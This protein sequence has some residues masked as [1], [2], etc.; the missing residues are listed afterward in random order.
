MLSGTPTYWKT[1]FPA[2]RLGAPKKT[3]FLRETPSTPFARRRCG[4]GFG[5]ANLQ[6]TRALRQQES[7]VSE[8]RST[9]S[10]GESVGVPTFQQAIQRLQN[11]W[12]E[13]TK[14]VVWLP[15]STE[16]G[17]GTMNPATFLR[18]LGPEPWHVCY[19]EPSIR[20]DDSRFGD[21][22]NRVQRHTQFQVILKPEPGNAQEL[23]LGS[24]EV[25][26]INVKKHDVRFVEDNW[27]SP[28]LG[29]WGLGWE[30]WLDGMEIT[31]FTYFQQAGGMQTDPVSV[32]I[33]YGLERILMSLQGVNH[34]KD[35]RYNDDVTYG[36]LFLQNEYEMSCYNIN[37]ASVEDARKR[38]QLFYKEGME[39]VE[40]K[41][42]VPAYDNLLKASHAF[43]VLD[44]RGAVGVTERAKL[45]GQ[46]RNLS[47]DCAEL[48]VER[49]EEL[50]FP[51]GQSRLG[52]LGDA[53]AEACGS[54]PL[55]SAQDFLLELGSEELPADEV[56]SAAGQ[57]SSRLRELLA[58]LRLEHGEVV[59]SGTPRRIFAV[60]RGLSPKQEDRVEEV[61][62][63]PAKIAFDGEGNPTKAVLGYCKKNG[64][65]VEDIEL[66]ADK[67][68]VEYCWVTKSVR[69][70][71]TGDLLSARLPDLVSKLQFRKSM[72]WSS[73]ATY[74]RPLR[75]I[76]ALHGD[77]VVPFV[78]CGVQSGRTSLGLRDGF[79]VPE[80]EIPTASGYFGQ[81]E[82][83]SLMVDMEKRRGAI[84][85]QSQALAAAAGGAIPEG[86]RQELLPEVTNLVEYPTAIMGSF[87]QDFLKL[88]KEILVMVMKK[89]QRYFP[90]E[91]AKTGQLLPSFVTIANGE[92][93][94]AT[95]RGGNEAVLTA[96]F[97]DADF[98]YKLDMQKRL[99]D[100][101]PL[102]Q[103]TMFQK[104]L[105]TMLDKADR[106][107]ALVG[108]LA[109]AMGLAGA[110]EVALQASHLS[111]ADLATSVVTEFTALAGVMGKHYALKDGAPVEVAEAIFESVLPRN[112]SD[113]VPKTPAGILVAVADRL[114]SLVGLVA[115]G[116]APT[117]T[118]DPYGLRRIA[119]GMLQT[120]IQNGVSVSLARA[121]EAAATRQ[122]VEVTEEQ[123]TQ[124]H[125][126]V[127]RRLEQL[128][129][130]DG[131]P[132]E[133]VR[134]V[135]AERSDDPHLAVATVADLACAYKTPEFAAVMASYSRPTKLVS[136]KDYD[137]GWTVDEGLFRQDE[138]RDLWAAYKAVE[139]EMGAA[140]PSPGVGAFVEASGA[141][142]APLESFFNSVFVMDEDE[143]VRSNRLAMMRDIAALPK[144]LLD[145]GSLPNF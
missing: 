95:V 142:E 74:S 9:G 16:V 44:A 122:P 46:M 130:D 34:F 82:G 120:L 84:W 39:L 4:A 2:I 67:K 71:A 121:I 27:E 110:R 19:P 25:L 117:A 56:S 35:I 79:H 93:D 31:Q 123:R 41:L 42:P 78:A 17:A 129:A 98:F 92:I 66:K 140:G 126:F 43:N 10:K 115:A 53:A 6:R 40:K 22:P 62:G 133:V 88:P 124:A 104:D 114:D 3:G 135:L 29:S 60:V 23:L 103:G 91:D 51:L 73:R 132:R 144:G 85:A 58:E 141:L 143:S 97:E 59:A 55:G 77:S 90:V 111:R 100:F 109:E 113:I 107:D 61:R 81:M 50:G 47:R 94:E 125:D 63:P 26:G 136:G 54:E 30:V 134:S 96:R 65:G 76:V 28:A 69:G 137:S 21:N 36:E 20:P 49:R 116:C 108:D 119:N 112:A 75:W 138:E 139:A 127:V 14:C 145:L 11:Y 7:S 1:W 89:H 12:S 128:L 38:F 70:E 86:M 83:S 18:V 57:V 68:G 72:R 87:A 5:T 33:T 32:E 131:S 52:D 106:T 8:G 45:F 15:H 102:L 37:E 24:L 118:A 105:G 13:K 64:V 80:I 99:S 48:W 101:R